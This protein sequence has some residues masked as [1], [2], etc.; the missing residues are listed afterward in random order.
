MDKDGNPVNKLSL[1][2]LFDF[3]KFQN[4]LEKGKIAYRIDPSA[5]TTVSKKNEPVNSQMTPAPAT[6]NPVKIP[7]SPTSPPAA[8]NK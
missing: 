7:I 3:I 4:D 8:N 5:P 2:E 6:N 1:E